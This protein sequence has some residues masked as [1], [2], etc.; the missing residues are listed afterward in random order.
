MSISED[1]VLKLALKLRKIL[2]RLY[3]FY[4]GV[5]AVYLSQPFFFS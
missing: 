3:I 2:S 5:F 4:V 1:T